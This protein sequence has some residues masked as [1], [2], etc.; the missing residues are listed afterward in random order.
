MVSRSIVRSEGTRTFAGVFRLTVRLILL[1]LTLIIATPLHLIFRAVRLPSPWPRLFLKAVGRICGAVVV[2]QGQRLTSDVFYVS[3]HVTWLD[4]PV[5]AGPTGAAFV[6]QAPIADWPLIG[7]LSKLNRTIFVSRTD[8]MSIAQQIDTLRDALDHH[9]PVVVFPEGTT[10]DGRS[11]LPFK[12]SLFEVVTPPPRPMLVQPVL[13][14][15][16]KMVPEYAWV[17]EEGAGA[18]AFRL[19]KR[20]GTFPVIVKFLEPIDPRA[21]PNRK[22]I[23]A[24]SRKRI[25]DALSASLGGI[26]IV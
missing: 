11:L 5:L 26:A 9:Q 19:L 22:A 18:N 2:T 15:Y 3:N 23:T 13:I 8:R 20:R 14:D 25:A 16:G 6:A 21:F 12:G 4:I 24:E 10:T 1:G 17:D 7:W